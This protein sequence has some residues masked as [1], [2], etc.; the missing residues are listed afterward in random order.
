MVAY[1]GQ[2]KFNIIYTYVMVFRRFELHNH[3]EV[4]ISPRHQEK[5][6]VKVPICLTRKASF[7]FI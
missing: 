4:A 5:I 2:E 3:T 1:Q 7:L 6:I